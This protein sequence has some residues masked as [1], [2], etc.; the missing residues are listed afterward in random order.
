LIVVLASTE[1]F[2]DD[3]DYQYSD[4]YSESDTG[5]AESG[6]SVLNRGSEFKGLIL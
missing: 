1:E 4:F 5:T 6:I 3:F 2:M